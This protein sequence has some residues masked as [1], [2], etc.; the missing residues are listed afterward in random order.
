MFLDFKD[1]KKQYQRYEM[2]NPKNRTTKKYVDTF[3]TSKINEM[4]DQLLEKT[5][6]ERYGKFDFQ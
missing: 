6:Q 2:W 4:K 3:E 5:K 1:M